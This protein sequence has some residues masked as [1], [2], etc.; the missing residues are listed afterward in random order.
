MSHVPVSLDVRSLLIPQIHIMYR[1]SESCIK[2]VLF[3]LL[4]GS[5]ETEPALG[6]ILGLEALELRESPW[7][8]TVK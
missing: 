1:T 3:V 4:E 8:I 6:I 7:F 2:L 5:K